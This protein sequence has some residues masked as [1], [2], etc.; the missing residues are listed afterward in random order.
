MH[1]IT[2][3]LPNDLYNRLDQLEKI[4]ERKKSYLIRK[5]VE[6]FLEEREDY[7]IALNRL[8]QKNPRISLEQLEDNNDLESRI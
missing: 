5:A 3:K 2:S 1:T 6:G 8:E 4:I 7:F